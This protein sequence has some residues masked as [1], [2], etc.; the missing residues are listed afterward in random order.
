MDNMDD[1]IS[2]LNSNLYSQ[3]KQRPVLRPIIQK[4]VKL[5][6]MPTDEIIELEEEDIAIAGTTSDMA[7]ITKKIKRKFPDSES[8]NS[9]ELKQVQKSHF[10]GNSGEKGK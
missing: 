10:F 5:K 8:I 2:I 9:E 4:P 1:L 7:E 3:P 6:N